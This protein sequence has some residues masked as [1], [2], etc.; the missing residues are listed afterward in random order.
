MLKDSKLNSILDFYIE[1]SAFKQAFPTVIFFM[2]A[3]MTIPVSSTT[4]E[5][6]CSRMKLIKTT[7]RS[8]MS[9]TRLSDLCI[10]PVER[11]FNIDFERFMR[12]FAD[13]HKNGR[14]LL[15]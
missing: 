2:A 7:A 3:A 9:D 5:R 10:L 12:N 14:I 11:V 15:K 13:L 8:T 1:L 6:T 4:Y